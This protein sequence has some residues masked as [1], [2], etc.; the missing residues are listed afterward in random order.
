VAPAAPSGVQAPVEKVVP[1][2][3]G[4]SAR[5]PRKH[6]SW[7]KRAPLLKWFWRP[8]G[9]LDRSHFFPAPISDLRTSG[10][11]AQI[12]LPP[13]TPSAAPPPPP[14]DTDWRDGRDGRGSYKRPFAAVAQSDHRPIQDYSEEELR[15]ILEARAAT[16][17]LPPW[18][19]RALPDA[20]PSQLLSPELLGWQRRQWP[21]QRHQQEAEAIS[22]ASGDGRPV[23]RHGV[24]M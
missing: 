7:P 20:R 18:G 8:K 12:H 23:M 15:E 24:L 14:M 10:G 16:G 6:N 22:H 1:G 11:G 17:R 21:V 13:L 3:S 5:F 9:T 19:C 2:P 4:P